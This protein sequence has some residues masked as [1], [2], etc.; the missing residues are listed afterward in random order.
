MTTLNELQKKAKRKM[1]KDDRML[2]C[3]V[4]DKEIDEGLSTSVKVYKFSEAL[5]KS[6]P[7]T[8]GLL[9]NGSRTGRPTKYPFAKLSIGDSFII[10]QPLHKCHALKNYWQKKCGRVFRLQK[11]DKNKTKA[12]RIS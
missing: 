5:L 9:V 7:S 12:W 11:V 2:A 3:E 4:F 6:A 8:G 1:E 10:K